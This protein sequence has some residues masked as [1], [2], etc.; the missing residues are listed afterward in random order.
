MINYSNTILGPLAIHYVGKKAQAEGFNLSDNLLEIEDDYLKSLMC[1]YFLGGFK[2]PSFY[3]FESSEELQTPHKLC[4]SYFQGEIDVMAL[5]TQLTEQLYEGSDHPS[6]K[7]GELVVCFFEDLILEDELLS[8]IGIF[9]VETRSAFLKLVEQASGYGFKALEGL[10]L[11]GLDKGCLVFNTDKSEGYKICMLDKNATAEAKFWSD[12]FLRLKESSDAY[13]HTTHYIKLTKDFIDDQQKSG[14]QLSKGEELEIMS[15]SQKFFEANESFSEDNYLESLFGDD[16]QVQSEFKNYKQ[17]AGAPD[18][19][20][21]FEIS[22][23]AVKK[24]SKFFRSVIKLDKNFHI[25]VH[26]D[27][28]KID[29]GTDEMG[30]KFYTLYYEEEH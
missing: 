21:E 16:E 29:R 28:T 9:K 22:T 10:A 24:H 26:G 4:E 18:L 1:Q 2:E 15:A 20:P 7:R 19:A 23:P 11:N 13:H 17:S 6:I 5:A 12:Q 3:N 14:S 8:A 27:K 25:Y 30:K